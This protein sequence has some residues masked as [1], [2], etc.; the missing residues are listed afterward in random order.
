MKWQSVKG[1][2]RGVISH[3][4]RKSDTDKDVLVDTADREV[5]V[6]SSRLNVWRTRS[7]WHL[8][9]GIAANPHL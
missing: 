1:N 3:T 8:R 4:P 6:N 9:S 2:S 5:H 7:I